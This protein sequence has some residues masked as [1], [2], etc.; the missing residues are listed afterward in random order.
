MSRAEGIAMPAESDF[1]ILLVNL[2][3]RLEKEPHERLLGELKTMSPPTQ[4]VMLR[5]LRRIVADLA[6]MDAAACE[7]GDA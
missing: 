3:A 1:W 4:A 7:S 5:R 6:A 2:S